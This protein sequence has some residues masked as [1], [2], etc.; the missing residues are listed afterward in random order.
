MRGLRDKVAIVTGAAHPDGIGGATARRLVEEGAKVLLTDVEDEVGQA[1]AQEL[2]ALYQHHDVSREA[3]WQAVIEQAVRTYGH[4]DILVNNAGV[5]TFA[6]VEQETL[7]GYNRVIAINQTGVWLGM[8]HAV[9]EM[10]KAGGG[11]IVNISSIFG[12]VG[13]F[14]ASVAYHS[15][16]GAVRLMTKNAALRYA[17]EGIRVNSVH[18]GFIDTPMIRPVKD[19]SD[20]AM[21]ATLQAILSLTPM[22]R[23]GKPEEIAAVIAFLASEE[24]SYCTGAEFH[25]DGGWT[26]A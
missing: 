12:T 5:G 11:S 16:K 25:A 13:G 10:R 19:P 2:G 1:F 8:K 3:D 9:P 4:L 15:A 20:P 26:A 14:G 21:A 23:L 22:G 17:K 18:P 24:A 7:E 6:D